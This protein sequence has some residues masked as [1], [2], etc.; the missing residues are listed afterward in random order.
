[1]GNMPLQV[2]KSIKEAKYTLSR[3]RQAYS[4]SQRK[5]DRLVKLFFMSACAN[6]GIVQF[7][8]LRST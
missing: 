2:A 6:L 4:L 8:P 3:S 7:G 5:G 1:M